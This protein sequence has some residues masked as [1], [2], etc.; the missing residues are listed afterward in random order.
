MRTVPPGRV[1]TTHIRASV[2]AMRMRPG[3]LFCAGLSATCLLLLAGGC[4]KDPVA[5]AG[6]ETSSAT[7][8]STGADTDTESGGE[9][10]T[11]SA[12]A[13]TWYQDIA[14]LVAG[15]CGGCHRGGTV[16]GKQFNCETGLG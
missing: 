11:G 2:I 9:S 15:S 13:P 5:S 1:T 10:E 16:S 6:S 8:G 3:S 7:D 14:P 4:G 12:I